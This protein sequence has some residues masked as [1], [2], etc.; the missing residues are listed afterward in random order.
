MNRPTVTPRPT[1][2]VPLRAGAPHR[3]TGRFHVPGR[4]SFDLEAD[5]DLL[6]WIARQENRSAAIRSAIREHISRSGVTLG[7]VYRAVKDLERKIETGAVAIVAGEGG[8][9][10]EVWD[11]PAD[12]AAALD[13][14]ADL[15]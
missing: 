12:A 11:E 9:G 10:P 15:G 3:G 7:D 8:E 5:K 6:R 4:R 1:L 13:A 14:L 2:D